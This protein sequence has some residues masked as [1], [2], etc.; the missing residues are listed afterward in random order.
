MPR[1]M[2]PAASTLS[3]ASSTTLFSISGASAMSR[4]P[5]SFAG[6]TGYPRHRT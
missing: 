6:L 5:A 4:F 2:N 3:E 1:R